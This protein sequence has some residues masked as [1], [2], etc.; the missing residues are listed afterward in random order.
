MVDFPPDFAGNFALVFPDV[1]LP[2]QELSIQVTNFDV[3]VIR[4]EDPPVPSG[5]Q[6]HQ[7]EHFDELAPQGPSTN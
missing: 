7:G 1:L 2:E 6:A 5:A 4:A 3:V